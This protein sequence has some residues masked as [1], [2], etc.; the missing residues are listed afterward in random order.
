[1]MDPGEECDDGNTVATDECTDLCTTAVCGDS[2]VQEGVETCDDGNADDLEC[3]AM[4]VRPDQVAA[5]GDHTCVHFDGGRVRCWGDGQF[6]QT[7]HGNTTDIG[8][9]EAPS[10][11]P[12]VDVGGVVV[13]VATG[14]DHTCALIDGGT[15]RCWGRG[16]LG[17]LGYGNTNNIGDDEAPSAAGDVN[18]GGTVIQV[19]AGEW[20]TCALLDG[21][22]VRCWGLGSLLGYDNVVPIG[23]DETPADAGDVD[24]GGPVAQLSI[25]SVHVCAVL[26]DGSVSCW[27]SGAD[28]QLGYGNTFDIGDNETP[29]SVG[30]VDVGGTAVQVAAGFNH[31]CVL[32]DD[33]TVRCWGSAEFGALGYGDA[34]DIGDDEVPSDVGTVDIGGTVIQVSAGKDFS[35]ALLDTGAVR[36]WGISGFG[37]LGYGNTTTIG[38][39][40]VPSVAGDIDMGGL[41]KAVSTGNTHSCALLDASALRCWGYG[42]YGHLGYGNAM[43][44]GDDE[45]PSSAGDVPYQ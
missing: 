23:D 39:D 11:V 28:G 22:A 14:K 25:G 33:G 2:V 38:N 6:G 40:E 31:S 7:G 12:D 34:V 13:Q 8:D 16:Q 45:A 32:L 10:T 29:A 17:R 36:C 19:A 9:T 42:V 1:M 37:Q 20:F 26:E 43:D 30:P 15:V 5:G 21:G 35:C 4:C 41:V 3:T 24:V 44:I 18:V 27:G